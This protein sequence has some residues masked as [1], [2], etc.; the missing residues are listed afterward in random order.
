MSTEAAFNGHHSNKSAFSMKSFF[1]AS[2]M[3]TKF[4]KSFLLTLAVGMTFGF[5]F[6]YLLLS[7]VSWEKVD[8]LGQSLYLTTQRYHSD[9]HDHHDVDLNPGPEFEVSQHSD[10]EPFHKGDKKQPYQ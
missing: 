4:S 10:N 5:S 6:A 8:F 1:V 7:V 9:L 3:H 2:Q